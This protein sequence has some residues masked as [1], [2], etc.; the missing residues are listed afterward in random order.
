MGDRG[1][2][3]EGGKRIC[4]PNFVCA[5]EAL[6]K[7]SK[8]I[9]KTTTGK[10]F[11]F[12]VL[13]WT[14]LQ[15]FIPGKNCPVVDYISIGCIQNEEYLGSFTCL[16]MVLCWLCLYWRFSMGNES[17]QKTCKWFLWL[18]HELS[19]LGCKSSLEQIR[20]LRIWSTFRLERLDTADSFLTQALGVEIGICPFC[21][22][23]GDSHWY[24]I[25]ISDF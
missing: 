1:L 6:E 10:S 21:F 13:S 12:T 16:H 14:S 19:N 25:R 22:C 2:E 18:L 5:R 7:N 23:E 11:Y 3:G 20:T 4:F 24:K 8:N 15:G 17:L 9:T